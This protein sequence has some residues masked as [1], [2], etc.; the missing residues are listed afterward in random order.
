[1][2]IPLPE[3]DPC[4]FCEYVARGVTSRGMRAAIVMERALT[5]SFIDPRPMQPGHVL[6]IPKRHAPT[7]IDLEP[8]EARQVIEHARDISVALVETLAAEGINAFQNNGVAAGQS[9]PHYHMHVV[10]RRPGDGNKFAPEHAR[11]I[12]PEADRLAM[13]QRIRRALEG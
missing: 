7:L 6:V 2:P 4:P 5:L 12:S 10:P 8:Q 9:V 11:A 13:A 3:A 1:M